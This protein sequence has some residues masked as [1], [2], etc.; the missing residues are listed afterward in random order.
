MTKTEKKQQ[1]IKSQ[2]PIISIKTESII[3][4]SVYTVADLQGE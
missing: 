4:G 1:Y 3:C 2:I